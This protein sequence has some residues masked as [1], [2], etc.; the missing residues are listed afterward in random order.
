MVFTN[1]NKTVH[2]PIDLTGTMH[3]RVSW[4]W[5]RSSYVILIDMCLKAFLSF[6]VLYELHS[7]LPRAPP[8]LSC[9][10]LILPSTCYAG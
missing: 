2:Q 8:V 7:I 4:G 9:A 5:Y 3:L 1:L 10:H 6:E